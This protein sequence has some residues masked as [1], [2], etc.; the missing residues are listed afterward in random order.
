MSKKLDP[1]F[2]SPGE[3]TPISGQWEV[4]GPRG[5]YRLI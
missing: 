5:G 4:V 3:I 2:Y 1:N